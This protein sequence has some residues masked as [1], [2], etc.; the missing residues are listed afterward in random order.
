MLKFEAYIREGGVEGCLLLNVLVGGDSLGDEHARSLMP[1][2]RGRKVRM[3]RALWMEGCLVN[4]HRNSAIL[5]KQY[6]LFHGKCGAA[7]I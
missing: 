5:L 1:R 4:C 6:R 7:A 2:K 3:M